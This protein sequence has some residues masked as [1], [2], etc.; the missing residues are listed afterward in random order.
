M[1]SLPPAGDKVPGSAPPAQDRVPCS[2]DRRQG[3]L[4]T[5]GLEADFAR[6]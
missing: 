4:V 1:T 5:A 2:A 6:G 3:D